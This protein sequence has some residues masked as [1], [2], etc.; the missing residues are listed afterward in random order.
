MDEDAIITLES[1]QIYGGGYWSASDPLGISSKSLFEKFRNAIE[2]AIV[3][4]C[5]EELEKAYY[6]SKEK[7]ASKVCWGTKT[8]EWVTRDK[9]YSCTLAISLSKRQPTWRWVC[10]RGEYNPYSSCPRSPLCEITPEEA[11]NPTEAFLKFLRAVVTDAF[12]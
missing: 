8:V 5:K 2:A 4:S 1:L 12:L 7:V 10:E 11:V 6:G 9:L 3:F